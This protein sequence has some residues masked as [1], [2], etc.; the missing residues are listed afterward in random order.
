MRLNIVLLTAQL[1]IFN[2]YLG[3]YLHSVTNAKFLCAID[4][5]H[6]CISASNVGPPENYLITN[7]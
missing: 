1:L 4:V 5:K 7:V 3:R 6:L 2:R